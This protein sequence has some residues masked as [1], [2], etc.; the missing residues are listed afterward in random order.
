MGSFAQ[1]K[2]GGL[3][4]SPSNGLLFD[5]LHF[6][7]ISIVLLKL[8]MT[9]LTKMRRVCKSSKAIIESLYEYRMLHEHADMTTYAAIS[10]GAASYFTVRELFLEFRHRWCRQCGEGVTGARLCLATVRRCCVRCSVSH[11]AFT[12][13]PVPHVLSKFGLSI[14][15]VKERLPMVKVSVLRRSKTPGAGTLSQMQDIVNLA[16]AK[17]LAIEI[18]GS[19][20]KMYEAASQS[21]KR[22][23]RE[24]EDRQTSNIRLAW[25]SRSALP[26]ISPAPHQFKALSQ[27]SSIWQD[28]GCSDFPFW[29]SETRRPRLN[30][31]DT[32]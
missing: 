22:A 12:L 13:V 32:F 17:S 9:S 8:D 3:A 26:P 30:I 18:Y 11:A 14:E 27:P 2:E 21:L 20:A 19:E 6:D 29:D 15:E 31:L 5:I 1:D 10:T 25:A 7:I 16:E 23:L 4:S 24:A 28:L